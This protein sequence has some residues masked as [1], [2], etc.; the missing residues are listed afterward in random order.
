MQHP[1]KKKSAKLGVTPMPH[2]RHW[3]SRATTFIF[4]KVWLT[5]LGWGMCGAQA[6]EE[7]A[8]ETLT[9][10]ACYT[11]A[12]NFCGTP[13]L[14]ERRLPSHPRKPDTA[15]HQHQQSHGLGGYIANNL[16]VSPYY[17][18]KKG[19][20]FQRYWAAPQNRRPVLG[21]NYLE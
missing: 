19:G 10:G 11:V 1:G 7:H 21:T 16:I 18:L 3:S 14:E 12:P 15:T 6:K 9:A 5:S 8:S 2:L 13:S 17:Y 4:V 20:H